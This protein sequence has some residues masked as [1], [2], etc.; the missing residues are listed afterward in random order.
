MFFLID[1]KLF[2]KINIAKLVVPI[3]LFIKVRLII[4][5]FKIDTISSQSTTSNIVKR[6]GEICCVLSIVG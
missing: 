3:I 6:V 1:D 5:P 4:I 2:C